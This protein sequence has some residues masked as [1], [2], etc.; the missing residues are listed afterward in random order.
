MSF[1]VMI[2]HS[3]LWHIIICSNWLPMSRVLLAEVVQRKNDE[4]NS[5]PGRTVPVSICFSLDSVFAGSILRILPRFKHALRVRG[6]DLPKLYHRFG[7]AVISSR[8]Q[9]SIFVVNSYS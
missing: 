5:G 1:S 6:D 7:V 2:H 3:L 4:L 9:S 8:K